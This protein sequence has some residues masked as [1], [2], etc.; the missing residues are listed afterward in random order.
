M[1]AQ[2]KL[3]G[4]VFGV[5]SYTMNSRLR[6][7]I[8]TKLE[9]VEKIAEEFPALYA[10]YRTIIQKVP[11]MAYSDPIDLDHL[12]S[13][14]RG[15]IEKKYIRTKMKVREYVAHVTILVHLVD[16]TP[17]ILCFARNGTPK[18]IP[19]TMTKPFPDTYYVNIR[20]CRD[21]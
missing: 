6:D 3:F 7:E 5:L 10:R 1:T 9:I 11:A 4:L 15:F 20:D 2:L 21:Y 16:L 13:H 17:D 8:R 19:S 12:T 18:I 14:I